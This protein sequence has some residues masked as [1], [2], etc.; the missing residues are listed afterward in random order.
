MVPTK[1]ILKKGHWSN[2]PS[3]HT[4]QCCQIDC[5]IFHVDV[6]VVSAEVV[7]EEI[8]FHC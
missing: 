7:V 6:I 5:L 4:H 3:H 2:I 8:D 1:E